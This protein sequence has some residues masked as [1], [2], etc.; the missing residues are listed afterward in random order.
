MMS[1]VMI[2]VEVEERLDPVGGVPY[3]DTSILLF[4]A[5]TDHVG[6]LS[7]ITSLLEM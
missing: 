7:T 6:C 2:V 4:P 1:V 5:T 3:R